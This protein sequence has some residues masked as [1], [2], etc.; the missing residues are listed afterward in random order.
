MGL[1]MDITL[2]MLNFSEEQL[3]TYISEIKKS[4][5]PKLVL[6]ELVD[7]IE[8]AKEQVKQARA[9]GWLPPDK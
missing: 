5:L 4:N 6:W 1:T 3:N 7:L 8:T 2:T 9:I